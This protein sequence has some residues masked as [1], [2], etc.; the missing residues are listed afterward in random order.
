ME[1]FVGAQAKKN[2]EFED[3]F[4]Q[5]NTHLTMIE[6]QLAQ[7]ANTIKEN[8]VHTSLPPQGQTPPKEMYS[9][10]TR[11]GKTIGDGVKS[12]DVFE[13]MGKESP[14][15]VE[16]KDDDIVE[17]ESS[18]DDMNDA[19]E[20]TKATLLPLPTPKL[21]FPQRFARHKLDLQI[22]KFLDVLSKMYV[23]LSLTEALKQM[24]RCSSF[25]RGILSGKRDCE[26]KETVRLT[27]S[28]SSQIQSPFPPKL[29]DPGSFSMPCRIQKL[30]FDNALCDLGASVSI[31]PYKIYERLSLGNLS[32]TPIS[33]QLD[34]RL[35]MYPLGRVEDVPLVIGKLTFLVYF[36]VLDIDEDVH[37]PIILGRPF[38]TTAGAL[39]DVQG[40]V[41]TLKGGDTKAS[42]KLPQG[43]GCFSKMFSCMKVDNVAC[44]FSNPSNDFCVSKCGIELPRSYPNDK[45]VHVLPRVSGDTFDDF[46]TIPERCIWMMMLKLLPPK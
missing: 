41:I 35:V 25:M 40:G 22:S 1:S 18:V 21:P 37:T 46:I 28:C 4:K 24:P 44:I 8:Q 7:L 26:K 36:V 17:D 33:L 31:M 45:K 14:W 20:P 12:S 34:D 16:S 32:P 5:S 19:L 30:K 10:V 42:F 23:S 29:K 43:E 3:G 2:V 11:S 13:P 39:I 6:T 27:E 9:I 15:V 38:L